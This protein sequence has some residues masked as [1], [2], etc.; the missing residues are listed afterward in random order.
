MKKKKDK[1]IKKNHER[2]FMAVPVNKL[3]T[4][5]FTAKTNSI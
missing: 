1:K 4:H 3:M 5:T 2:I